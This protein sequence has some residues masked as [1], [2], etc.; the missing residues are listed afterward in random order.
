MPIPQLTEKQVK[1]LIDDPYF[2]RGQSYFRNGNVSDMVVRDDVLQGSCSGSHDEIYQV[3]V[4]FAKD[5]IT[6]MTCSCPM[7]GHCKHLAALLLTWVYRSDEFI[8]RQPLA[9][10]LKDCSPAELIILIERMVNRYPN[11]EQLVDLFTTKPE[12]KKRAVV[13]IKPYQRQMRRIMRNHEYD[14]SID[15]IDLE[16][17][18]LTGKSFLDI[19]NWENAVVVFRAVIEGILE[20]YE[21]FRDENGD[22]AITVENAINGLVACFEQCADYTIRLSILRI[23]F[24]TTKYDIEFGG[25]DLDT[26]ADKAYDQASVAEKAEL[27]TWIEDEIQKLTCDLN[28]DSDKYNLDAWSRNWFHIARS[29]MTDEAL[30]ETASRLKM[31]QILFLHLLALKRPAEA[32]AMAR[33]SL[34]Y[35]EQDRLQIVQEL[36]NA[37]YNAEALSLAEENLHVAQKNTQLLDWVA[38][39]YQTQERWADALDLYLKIWSNRPDLIL[40]RTLCTLGGKL[41]NWP[42]LQEKLLASL[43]LSGDQDLLLDIYL[44]EENWLAAWEL[45]ESKKNRDLLNVVAERTASFMPE[46]AIPVYITEVE[47]AIEQRNRKLYEHAAKF[48]K[49]AEPLFQKLNR[50]AEWHDYVAKL[51]LRYKKLPALLDEMAKAGL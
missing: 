28:S 39:C 19:S 43:M 25:I 33:K 20:E 49:K 27:A 42:T 21:N 9:K 38:K 11:L 7:G 48:L 29:F 16:N 24:E 10:V 31:Y 14:D 13:S 1:E 15:L 47:S 41:N 45:A 51:R 35:F 17:I 36:S 6:N 40:Y 37:G 3:R 8:V 50:S 4:T 23:L 2:S 30:L 44:E 22:L 34:A 18:L 12:Q 46:R 26:G 32:I 5:K